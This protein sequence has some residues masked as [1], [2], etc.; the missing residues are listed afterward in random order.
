MKADSTLQEEWRSMQRRIVDHLREPRSSDLAP[1]P[2]RIPAASYT[3]PARFSAERQKIFGTEPLLVGFSSDLP[4]PGDRLTFDAAGPPV[5]V[6]RGQD[7]IV[8]AFLNICPHRGARLV[9]DCTP[10]RRIT[11]P[12]H[13]W[14]FD[15]RG[16]LASQP[17]AI[18]FD[19]LDPDSLGLTLLPAEEWQG[20]IF[21]RAMPGDP[22]DA[23]TF[24]GP[25]GPLLGALN[26]GELERVCSD[27]VILKSNWKIA[28]DTFCETYHVPA[29]HQETLAQNL[30]P[31]I[32]IF[33]HYGQHHRYSGPG[34]DFTDLPEQSEATWPTDGYQAVHYIF[35]N[36]TF[37]YTH[38]FD[39]KTPVVSMFQIF[40]GEQV[41]ECVTIGS[42]YRRRDS[43][44]ASNA[45]DAQVTEMHQMV[46][47][48]VR[49]EDYRIA[50]QVWENLLNAPS[51]FQLI[52]GR[53][54]AL[55]HHYHRDLA[56]RVGMP[57]P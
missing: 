38:A 16:R 43:S 3:D 8:R 1:A 29:L 34:T 7:N 21:V 51:D 19:G 9:E 35:P 46:L 39:G 42:T 33:D 54:E 27:T 48:I 53:T 44:N 17:Q 2:M 13:A 30:I 49:N 23:E 52:F 36:T 57:L 22:I 55:L 50:P 32:S 6:I 25:M 10:S 12:F 56:Q 28:L 41:G 31:Y 5:L 18:A 11:C 45:S 14:S 20:M 15:L 4:S 47:D 24:M 26:L 40:P 37:A